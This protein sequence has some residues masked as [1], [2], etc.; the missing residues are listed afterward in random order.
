MN[1]IRKT[2]LRTRNFKAPTSQTAE[3]SAP[4]PVT[5]LATP[6]IICYLELRYDNVIIFVYYADNS[7][8]VPGSIFI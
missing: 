7:P 1:Y 5:P 3:D 8:Y 4:H 6:E 2:S